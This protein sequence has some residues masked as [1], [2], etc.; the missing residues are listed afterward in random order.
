MIT[1]KTASIETQIFDE[2]NRL[3][4]A[5]KSSDI[6][7]LSSLL[8][9]DLLF[10]TPDGLT[11]TKKMD[12]DAH[13]AGKMTVELFISNSDAINVIDDIAISV[14]TVETKGTMLNQPIEGFFKYIRIWK[15]FDENWKVVGGSCT[16]L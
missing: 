9:D 14:S 3:I 2:E 11:I 1:N 16:K 7:T 10:I 6:E 5:M 13:R 15:S 8:H 4:S 12:L